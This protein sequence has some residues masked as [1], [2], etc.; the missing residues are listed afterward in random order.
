MSKN[1]WNNTPVKLPNLDSITPEAKAAMVNTLN[2]L[3]KEETKCDCE[4]HY[5]LEI[6]HMAP[7]CDKTYVQFNSNS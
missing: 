2:L 1:P 7:C 4:C 3:I 5:D 6:M